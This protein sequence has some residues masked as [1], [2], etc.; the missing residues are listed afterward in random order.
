MSNEFEDYA[1]N[2][3]KYDLYFD[4]KGDIAVN[5]LNVTTEDRIAQITKDIYHRV[6]VN[7]VAISLKDTNE[8]RQTYIKSLFRNDTRISDFTVTVEGEEITVS[9]VELTDD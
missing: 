9:N 5:W 1:V 6:A 8:E 4:S 7:W 2:L 3:E